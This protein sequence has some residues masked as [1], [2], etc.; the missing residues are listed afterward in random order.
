MATAR[1]ATIGC[2]V[3]ATIPADK[4][5]Y[6]A[7]T[8][9][10]IGSIATIGPLGDSH[11]RIT[12]PDLE[13]GRVDSFAGTIDAGELSVAVNTENVGS[14]GDAGQILIKTNSGNDTTLA[15]EITD[16]G[17]AKSYFIG[18]VANYMQS[19]RSPS[20]NQGATFTIWR[21]TDI[22]T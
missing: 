11:E 6:E 8:Y 4:S 1:G 5:A 15:F 2:V 13:D 12:V 19:E 10:K 22:T 9:V 3:S 17:G 7:L 14:G 16:R 18:R 21:I 20:V